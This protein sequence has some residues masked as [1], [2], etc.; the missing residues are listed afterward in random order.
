V[1]SVRVYKIEI[2]LFLIN[3]INS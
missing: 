3:K 2:G 1:S